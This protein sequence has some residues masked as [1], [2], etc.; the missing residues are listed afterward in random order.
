MMQHFDIDQGCKIQN[1]L[2]LGS[3]SPFNP[4]LWIEST[5]IQKASITTS[6]H[7]T[8]GVNIY[9]TDGLIKR[10]TIEITSTSS[11]TGAMTAQ[12]VNLSSIA[13]NDSSGLD[14]VTIK[15]GTTLEFRCK[16]HVYCSM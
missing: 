5:A 9:A 14:K 8:A 15:G 12:A 16:I 3:Y 11:F 7:I 2:L 13:Y 1:N 4:T 6:N 10:R